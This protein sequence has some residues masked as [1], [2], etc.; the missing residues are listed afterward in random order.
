MMML[1]NSEADWFFQH[2]GHPVQEQRVHW[3]AL[4]GMWAEEGPSPHCETLTCSPHTLSSV[5]C[6]M[7]LWFPRWQHWQ[8]CWWWW[9]IPWLGP[10]RP[11]VSAHLG[12]ELSWGGGRKGVTSVSLSR[13]H[14]LKNCD[15]FF[16]HLLSW[17]CGFSIPST[18]QGPWMLAFWVL[19]KVPPFL[20]D[21]SSQ[22]SSSKTSP[23]LHPLP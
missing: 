9:A 15:I 21:I 18:T 23:D 13:P 4:L 12:G 22:L 3:S 5:P 16:S 2:L 10:G 14:P 17:S 19:L 20:W 1:L 11:D 8:W 7:C 6:L